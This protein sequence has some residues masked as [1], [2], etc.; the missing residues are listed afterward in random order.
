MRWLW[1]LAIPPLLSGCAMPAAFTVASLT[2]DT[3]SYMVSGKTL[4]DHGL[5]LAMD[6]DCSMMRVLDEDHA[7]C[8]EDQEYEVAVAAL[9][10]LPDN[11]DLDIELASGGAPWESNAYAQLASRVH[12]ART[13]P[14]NY[15]TAGMMASGL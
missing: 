5:S 3:G 7:I 4:T 6:E 12:K 2:L 14:A 11:G 8:Q 1:L 15:L 10:P 13:S 9:T